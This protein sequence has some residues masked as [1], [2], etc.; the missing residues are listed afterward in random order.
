MKNLVHSI[1]ILGV[2]GSLLA[3]SANA[4]S[5][6]NGDNS[7]EAAPVSVAIAAQQNGYHSFASAQSAAAAS[8]GVVASVKAQQRHLDGT[9]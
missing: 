8:Q 2:A 9:E 5:Y 6:L 7:H 4:Q 1:A 3:G